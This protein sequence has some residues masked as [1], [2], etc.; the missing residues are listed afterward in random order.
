VAYFALLGEPPFTGATVEQVLTRQTANQ[1]P[2]LRERRPD[3][4]EDLASVLE[5]ALSAEVELR[6]PSAAEFLQAINRATGRGLR[7]KSGE[8][9]KAA[10]RWWKP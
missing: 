2:E 3:I 10:M 7:R 4:G 1:R 8:W 9:T 5:R 6:Y